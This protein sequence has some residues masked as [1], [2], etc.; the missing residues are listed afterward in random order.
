MQ[1]LTDTINIRRLQHYLYCPH[2]WGLLEIGDCWV[3]NSFVVKANIVHNRVHS[4]DNAYTSKNKFVATGTSVWCDEPEYN[5]YGVT[6]CIEFIKAS[7]GVEIQNYNGKYKVC[8]V[9]YKPTKPKNSDY[10]FEDA[11]Q[12][13]AQKLCVDR[14]YQC[15]SD[16]VI[17]YSDVKKRFPVR[18]DDKE[19]FESTLKRILSEMREYLKRGI[20]PP[21]R[22]E[23][24]CSGCSMKDLCIPKMRRQAAVFEQIDKSI[25]EEVCEN[26]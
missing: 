18:F 21:V 14:M 11:L 23:Q 3:E 17:Y 4:P 7:D 19:K 8:I 12:V 22:K 5:I 24:K 2:R 10:Y 6:D 25:K 1:N 26:F 16:A 13:Y 9:E 20:I 15:D